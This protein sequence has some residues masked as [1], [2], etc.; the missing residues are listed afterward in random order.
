MQT[1]YAGVVVKFSIRF[2]DKIVG[3]LVILALAILV[4]VIFMVG[5]NQRWFAHD[6]QYVTYFSSASGLSPNMAVYYRGFTIGNVKKIKL[7]DDSVEVLFTI[8]EEYAHRVTEGSVVEVQVNPIGLGSTFLFHPG[9][10]MV[11]H[12]EGDVIP[13]INSAQARLLTAEGLVNRSETT[14]DITNIISRVNILLETIDAVLTGSRGAEDL[15]I[16]Q[17]V[18]NL[19]ESLE[20]INIALSGSDGAEDLAL[21]QIVKNLETTTTGLTSL[22]RTLSAQLS[23]IMGNLDTVAAQ[24]SDPSGTVMSILD[25]D[26]PVYTNLTSAMNSIASIIE[27]LDRTSEFIPAQLPQ[28]GVM[29]ADLNIALRTAQDVLTAIANNP[30]L[31]GGIPQHRETIPGGTN[32]RNLDF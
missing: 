11:K 12:D 28:I 6:I 14:N 17:I 31:K 10:G 3:S 5:R 30:L 20:T 2:A 13:E 23:P 24:L 9:K 8:H 18:K 29:I 16:G 27:N 26:G 22:A 15:A 32:P 1:R 7:K 25:V 19:E 21:G 4:V